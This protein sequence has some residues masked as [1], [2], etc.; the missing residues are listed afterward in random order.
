VTEK[1]DETF[2][3]VSL[4]TFETLCVCVCVSSV[5]DYVFCVGLTVDVT[6]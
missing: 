2:D 3:L 5:Y 6:V 4:T 1:C